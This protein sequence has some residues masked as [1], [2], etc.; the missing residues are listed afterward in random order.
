[1]K[2]HIYKGRVTNVKKYKVQDNGLIQGVSRKDQAEYDLSRRY[3]GSNGTYVEFGEYL[4]MRL[5]VTYSL[6]D[7]EQKVIEL[8]GKNYTFPKRV[9]LNIYHEVMELWG[10][11]RMSAEMYAQIENYFEGQK[12]E[13]VMIPDESSL[14]VN[15]GWA[16]VDMVY[17]LPLQ[18]QNQTLAVKQNLCLREKA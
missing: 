2:Q 16:T 18:I 5:D 7:T 14:R 4:G 17:I 3:A 15:D 10:K 9:T 6:Y 1:M 13:L 8:N 12:R 11:Q